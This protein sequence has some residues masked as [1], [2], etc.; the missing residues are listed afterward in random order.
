MKRLMSKFMLSTAALAMLAS[1][2]SNKSGD[3]VQNAGNWFGFVVNGVTGEKLNFFGEKNDTANS[4]STDQVYVISKGEVKLAEPCNEGDAN[5]SNGISINGCVTVKNLPTEVTI[6]VF[7]TR[8]GFH[9]FGSTMTVNANVSNS[10]DLIITDPSAYSNIRLFPTGLNYD[11]T[12]HTKLENDVVVEGVTVRCVYNAQNA[13]DIVGWNASNYLSPVNDFPN[14]ITGTSNADGKVVLAGTSL[15]PGGEY[16]CFGHKADAV[17]NNVISDNG[18]PVQFTVG[19]DSP[20]VEFFLSINSNGG[21]WN[22]F[23]ATSVNY[24]EY[25]SLGSLTAPLKINFNQPA[26]VF[27]GT[28]DC[29]AM[30]LDS[31]QG[32]GVDGIAITFETD[33][34]DPAGSENAESVTVAMDSTSR[35]LSLTPVLATGS[36]TDDIQARYGFGGIFVMPV[37]GPNVGSVYYVDDDFSG[38]GFNLSTSFGGINCGSID[39][40]DCIY[41]DNGC[42]DNI[43]LMN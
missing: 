26:I 31:N 40:Q 9:A 29:Q 32:N 33:V 36:S 7:A 25:N 21:P 35:Q 20:E 12:I 11:V 23:M 22:S 16:A 2:S 19:V 38:T 42:I 5:D 3:K 18:N 28:E 17:N 27:P 37:S 34:E 30:Y 13:L 4:D 14:V 41:T 24:S 10:N 6:P 1:C 15:T 39:T 8:S 43:A